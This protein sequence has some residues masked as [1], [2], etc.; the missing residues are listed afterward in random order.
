MNKNLICFLTLVSLVVFLSVSLVNASLDIG[1]TLTKPVINPF[2]NQQIVA[3]TNTAG[4]GILFVVQPASGTADRLELTDLR[5]FLLS[6][7][8][9][10]Q[11]ELSGKIGDKIVSFKLVTLKSGETQALS[12]PADFTGVN[13]QPS[14]AVGGTYKVLFVFISVSGSNHR[15][16]P[17]FEKDFSCGSFLV[18]P[19]SPIGTVMALAAPIVAFAGFKA[20]RKDSNL[21]SRN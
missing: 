16:L 9:D 6:V 15:C 13:G 10:V 12:F 2:E 14:T 5:A 8:E 11:N 21:R 3:T 18:T 4:Y 17:I 19:E 7:P 1:A 20:Y